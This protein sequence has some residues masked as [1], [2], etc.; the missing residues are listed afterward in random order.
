MV[1]VIVVVVV[2]GWA[3][4]KRDGGNQSGVWIFRTVSSILNLKKVE[5]KSHWT[6]IRKHGETMRWVDLQKCE[7]YHDFKKVELKSEWRWIRKRR[8]NSDLISNQAIPGI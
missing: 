8:W 1:V 2:V 7:L 3:E 5:L 6:W 4:E